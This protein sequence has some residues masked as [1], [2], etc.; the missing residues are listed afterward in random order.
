MEEARGSRVGHRRKFEPTLVTLPLPP[1][2]DLPA[3]TNTAGAP[4][5]RD[6]A[7]FNQGIPTHQ[8]R[9]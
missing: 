2:E 9:G 1:S 7:L 3:H 5:K 8:V 6:T 4:T